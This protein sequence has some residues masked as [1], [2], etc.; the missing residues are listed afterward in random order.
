M[1]DTPD[2][3]AAAPTALRF[4][5]GRT[6]HQAG[7]SRLRRSRHDSSRAARSPPAES[8]QG[9]MRSTARRHRP[10]R[11]RQPGSHALG[12]RALRDDIEAD[13][14]RRCRQHRRSRLACEHPGTVPASAN[15]RGYAFRGG[16]SARGGGQNHVWRAS[17]VSKRPAR[18]C[19]SSSSRANPV[20]ATAASSMTEPLACPARSST[21]ATNSSTLCESSLSRTRS[22]APPACFNASAVPAAPLRRDGQRDV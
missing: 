2:R 12:G 18:A 1:T 15:G 20:S 8:R 5:H 14:R 16:G 7:R 3:R 17:A 13:S 22:A 4:S 11:A 21:Q 9:P 10:R 6:A 19:S